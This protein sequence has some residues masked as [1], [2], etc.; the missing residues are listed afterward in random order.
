MPTPSN[1]VESNSGNVRIY[2]ESVEIMA[3]R[4]LNET[5]LII[6]VIYIQ[7]GAKLGSNKNEGWRKKRGLE[8][9]GV[10]AGFGVIVSILYFILAPYKKKN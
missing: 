10:L 2:R 4:F 5:H 1:G 8:E 9:R 3:I 6:R 7:L